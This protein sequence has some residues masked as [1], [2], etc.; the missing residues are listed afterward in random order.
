MHALALH[1]VNLSYLGMDRRT[2]PYPSPKMQ[3]TKMR[4]LQAV[5]RGLKCWFMKSGVLMTGLYF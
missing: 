2:E 3:S 4:W 5:L 1:E